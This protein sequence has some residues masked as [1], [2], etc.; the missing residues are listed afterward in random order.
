MKFGTKAI[1]AGQ[2]PDPTTGAIMTPIYQT[3]TYVQEYPLKHKGYEYARTGNP[4]RTA[5]E[6]NIAALENGKF[7]TAFSSGLAATDAVMKLFKSGDHIIA[8]NDLYGGTYRIFTKIFENYG[9]TFSFV[10][11]TDL[12]NIEK[13]ITASTKLIW[14]ETPTNPLLR[15]VD[16]K[17]ITTLAKSKKILTL[18]D[19]TFASPFIQ[20]PLELGSDLVLHSI[21]KYLSGH[22]DL[23]SGIVITNDEEMNTRLKFIQ[24]ASGAVPGP[25][26]CFLALRGT[27]TLHLRMKAHCENAGKVAEWLSNH[28]KVSQVIYPGLT[29]HPQHEIAK[30]QMRGFGGML[31][32]YLK[33]DDINVAMKLTSL[34]KIFSL[35]ESLGG[36]E[37]LIEHPATMT[38]A[39]IPREIRYQNGFYDGLIR[40]SVGVEDSEDIMADLDQALN[41]I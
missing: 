5:L 36:V 28:S 22:S 34:T 25:Q 20:N 18:V 6:A 21:T 10:D 19:N 33:N 2:Q 23:V 9:M 40:L 26:D 15:I 29:S 35:A 3:S 14:I 1:H 31:S 37:S 16:I 30:K 7:G 39:S 4:T 38:H 32:F 13:A 41:R 11:M 12:S 17:N 24:N 27:K 8:S